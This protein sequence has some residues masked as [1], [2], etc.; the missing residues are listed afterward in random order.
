M[1]SQLLLEGSDLSLDSLHEVYKFLF[2]Y[3]NELQAIAI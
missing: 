2:L 3:K 1:N